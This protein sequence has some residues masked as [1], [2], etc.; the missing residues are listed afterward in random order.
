LSQTACAY[1]QKRVFPEP[2]E[3]EYVHRN[4]HWKHQHYIEGATSDRFLTL[5]E[6]IGNCD[7]S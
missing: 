5:S 2:K 4:N 3:I 7:P 1:L 6:A